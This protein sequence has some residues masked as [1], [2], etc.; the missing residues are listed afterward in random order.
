MTFVT[1][2]GGSISARGSSLEEWINVSDTFGVVAGANV[3]RSVSN[4]LNSA[5]GYIPYKT[6]FVDT[7]AAQSMS[8]ELRKLR[9]DFEA[10]AAKVGE[11]A[12]ESHSAPTTEI[13]EIPAGYGA[14]DIAELTLELGPDFVGDRW[15]D[16]F[17]FAAALDG[18]IQAAV[19]DAAR[20]ALTSPDPAVRSAAGRALIATHDKAERARV[21]RHVN[22][23]ESRTVARTLRVALES[24]SA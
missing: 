18:E 2:L 8:Y 7:E 6:T 10:L 5:V 23:E 22:V 1:E 19:I 20:I 16:L 24:A 14:V 21:E 17:D 11:L 3:N 12:N 13:A 15:V 4:I 9:R